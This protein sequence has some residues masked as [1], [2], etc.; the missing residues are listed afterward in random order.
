[1]WSFL[2]LCLFFGPWSLVLRK[3]YTQLKS[4][5][6]EKIRIYGSTCEP[7]SLNRPDLLWKFFWFL[8]PRTK[9]QGT[10]NEQILLFKFLRFWY[11]PSLI[12]KMKYPYTKKDKRDIMFYMLSWLNF[13]ALLTEL[14]EKILSL[15]LLNSLDKRYRFTDAL[16]Q[17]KC[18]KRWFWLELTLVLL[19]KFYHKP[20]TFVSTNS[21]NTVAKNYLNCTYC[22]FV[23]LVR[24]LIILFLIDFDIHP[25]YY[26][27][28]LKQLLDSL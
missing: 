7:G 28:S 17:L 14:T 18:S 27:R 5:S 16:K 11:W 6:H 9:K 1:M 4:F 8:K 12:F 19:Q 21:I 24:C 23:S 20:L 13:P 25:N 10:F 15:W 26:L 3:R 2:Q 22:R